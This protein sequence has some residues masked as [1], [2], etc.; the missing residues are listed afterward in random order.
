MTT[1]ANKQFVKL[2]AEHC[3]ELF[4][5]ACMLEPNKS[6]AEDIVQEVSVKL[7][8]KFEQFDPEQTDFCTW[9]RGFVR[10]QVLQHRRSHARRS[11]RISEDVV[12]LLTAD[13][14]AERELFEAQ[15][16]ALEA[17]LEKLGEE[18]RQLVESRYR[19][20][21]GDLNKLAA[22]MNRSVNAVSISLYRVRRQLV[23][24]TTEEMKVQG[25]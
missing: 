13:Y 25:W 1:E 16:T 3:F 8:E 17:C 12:D 5:Y 10:F 22:L 20:A 21:H 4:R 23:R 24:C 9:A 18:A 11:A 19:L 6:D 2:Y 7:W 15:Q 14:T